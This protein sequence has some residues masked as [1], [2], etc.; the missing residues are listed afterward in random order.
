MAEQNVPSP[1][2]HSNSATIVLEPLRGLQIA[3]PLQASRWELLERLLS[4]QPTES[5]GSETELFGKAIVLF[6]ATD[7]WTHI[8]W[9]TFLPTI[10]TAQLFEVG[11]PNPQR[12]RCLLDRKMKVASHLIETRCT[13]SSIHCS[14]PT[15]EQNVETQ[16]PTHREQPPQLE[17]SDSGFCRIKQTAPTL[18]CPKHRTR[19]RTMRRA[20]T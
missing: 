8:L 1:R 5:G 20:V 18:V 10:L 13:G 7:E 11:Q 14:F 9:S 4:A 16:N 19:R 2:Y 15:V 12:L 6:L 3:E 17:R